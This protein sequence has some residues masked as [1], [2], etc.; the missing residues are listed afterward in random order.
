MNLGSIIQNDKEIAGDVTIRK[1]WRP[2]NI[3][4]IYKSN[5]EDLSLYGSP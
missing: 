3:I 4:I 1:R 2:R 5:M